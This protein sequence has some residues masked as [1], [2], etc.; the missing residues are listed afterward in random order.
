MRAHDNSFYPF[1]NIGVAKTKRKRRQNSRRSV[2]VMCDEVRDMDLKAALQ[3][4]ALLLMKSIEKL[5][6]Q[7]TEEILKQVQL[8]FFE[9]PRYIQQLLGFLKWES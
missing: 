6:Q 1:H 5:S 8:F 7:F 2:P 9:Q 4:I 3:N